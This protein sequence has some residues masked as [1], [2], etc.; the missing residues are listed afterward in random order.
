[1]ANPFGAVVDNYFLDRYSIYADK[2]KTQ[3]YRAR[4]ALN[5]I[6]DNGKST[7]ALTYVR[8]LK[9][10]YGKGVTTHITMYNATGDTLRLVAY[11][12]GQGHIG[13]TPYPLVIGN[14][15]WVSFLHVKPTSA[16]Q[17]SSGFL[18]YRAKNASGQ[19]RDWLIGWRVPWKAFG[20]PKSTVLCDV[21][22]LDS[23]QKDWNALFRRLNTSPRQSRINKDGAIIDVDIGSGTSPFY[24]AILQTPHSPRP[25]SDNFI[26][27]AFG[28]KDLEEKEKDGEQGI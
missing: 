10:A 23:F 6:N 1:M 27:G 9:T 22:R 26:N 4:E 28:L 16:S 3:E 11:R 13:G 5:L 14:G 17:G 19:D 20:N 12:E 7:D 2:K 25:T 21:G 8:G 24:R 18:V 15:Q